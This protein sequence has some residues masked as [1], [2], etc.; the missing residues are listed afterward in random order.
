MREA[1]AAF[2]PNLG[3]P[4]LA[5][6]QASNDTSLAAFM[7]KID[8]SAFIPMLQVAIAAAAPKLDLSGLDGFERI[9]EGLVTQV[10]TDAL[11]GLAASVEQL[12]PALPQG[13]FAS[14]LDQD[15]IQWA[16][17]LNFDDDLTSDEGEDG[18]AGG[19]EKDE[20]HLEHLR[21][22]LE[23]VARWLYTSAAQLPAGALRLNATVDPLNEN[24]ARYET[25]AV[26]LCKLYVAIILIKH[27]L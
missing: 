22:H 11:A 15:I 14:L 1:F 27:V 26:T 25:L 23:Q 2:P 3:L 24:I 8:T 5:R 12:I 10:S 6:L 17:N 4:E 7:S 16:V 13:D 18:A 21:E 9:A 20:Q 19:G